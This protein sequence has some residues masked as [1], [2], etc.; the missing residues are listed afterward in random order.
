VIFGSGLGSMQTLWERLRQP[1]STN[2][3]GR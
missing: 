2:K 1:D 3:G